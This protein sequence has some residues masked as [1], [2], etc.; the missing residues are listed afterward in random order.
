MLVL[1][2]AGLLVVLVIIVLELVSQKARHVALIVG[3]GVA[4]ASFL[5]E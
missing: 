1:V 3:G 2:G 5:V 4:V